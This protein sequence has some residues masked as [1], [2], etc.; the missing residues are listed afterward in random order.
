M[1]QNFTRSIRT[2]TAG[3]A[4]T[5]M[6]SAAAQVQVLDR[7]AITR[8]LKQRTHGEEL[9]KRQFAVEDVAAGESVNI[10]KVLRCDDLMTQDQFRQVG[11]VLRQFL[12]Y[13]FAKRT[14]LALPV[15][16]F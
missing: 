15:A 4:C 12:D 5:R 7:G 6:G 10:F 2:G 14:S 1:L 3:Q 11:C 13:G 9:V 8:P 16:G